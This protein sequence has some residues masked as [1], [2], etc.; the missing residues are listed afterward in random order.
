MDAARRGYYFKQ[1]LQFG[2]HFPPNA[3]VAELSNTTAQRLLDWWIFL[4]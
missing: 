1:L 3:L 2:I 4:G